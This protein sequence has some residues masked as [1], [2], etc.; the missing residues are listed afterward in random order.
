MAL[1]ELFQENM[2]QLLG[3]EYEAYLESFSQKRVY[4]LRVNTL[5]ISP[6]DFERICPFPVE[7]IP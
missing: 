1:P 2:R 5:K 6:E 7:R 3:G 4:G